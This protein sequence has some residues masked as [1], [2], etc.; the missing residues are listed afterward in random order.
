MQ[1][2]ASKGWPCF[3]LSCSTHAKNG[4]PP[5]GLCANNPFDFNLV[6]FWLGFSCV[7]RL[8]FD[9]SL[10]LSDILFKFAAILHSRMRIKRNTD[11]T[12]FTGPSGYVR[13]HHT[14]GKM[15]AVGIDLGNSSI[16][17]ALCKVRSI[18]VHYFS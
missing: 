5:V 16:V 13:E 14:Y 7:C 3:P 15:A 8:I 4:G 12:S 18:E 2:S 10:T 1:T 11:L 6:S 9:I 17:I